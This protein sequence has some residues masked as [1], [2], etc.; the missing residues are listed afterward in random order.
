MQVGVSH[1]FKVEIYMNVNDKIR[2]A[3][4]RGD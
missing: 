3:A 1:P 4:N 2:P